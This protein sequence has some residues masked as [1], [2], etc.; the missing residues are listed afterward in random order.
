M[1]DYVLLRQTL[2][3][4]LG[5]KH[6]TEFQYF[7]FYIKIWP[8][9]GSN[10]SGKMAMRPELSFYFGGLVFAKWSASCRG[11]SNEETEKSE[12]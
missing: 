10:L 8:V 7:S 5:R 4:S 1:D 3:D 9:R 2:L 12:R 11:Y 6:M